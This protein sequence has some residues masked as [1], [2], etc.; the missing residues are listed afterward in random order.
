LENRNDIYLVLTATGRTNDLSELTRVLH[1]RE[2]P[3][4]LAMIVSDGSLL[5]QSVASFSQ[6]LDFRG[7][8]ALVPEREE[9]AALDQLVPWPRVE[10]TAVPPGHGSAC[11]LLLVLSDILLRSPHAE[12]VVVSADCYVPDP[13]PFIDALDCAREKLGLVSAVLL[14][15]VATGPEDGRRW[16]VP[17]RRLGEDVF[18]LSHGRIPA[19]VD[20]CATLFAQ[21]AMW[22][23]S[24]FIARG[25][26]LLRVL[27]RALPLQAD[28]LAKARR[29]GRYSPAELAEVLA[30]FVP[31]P[32]AVELD[33]L[34]MEEIGAV[35]VARVEGSGW[36]DWRT[37]EQVLRSLPSHFEQ[38]WL[39][40]R[41]ASSSIAVTFDPPPQ[42]ATVSEPNRPIPSH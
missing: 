37:L 30:D 12:I 1:G 32:C 29:S 14:G 10:V 4:A 24:A 11:A 40:S 23:T 18:T 35:A 34:M 36:S 6:V 41:L 9:E 22:N 27:A 5:Q 31:A 13:R 38:A 8:I 19:S 17:G 20:E 7:V 16:L 28:A 2:V 33:D 39:S 26:F 15:A 25:Q 3:K 42:E 21:E